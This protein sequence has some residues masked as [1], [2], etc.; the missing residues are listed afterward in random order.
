M[1]GTEERALTD[2]DKEVIGAARAKA[3]ALYRGEVVPHHSCGAALA[4]TFNLSARPYQALRRGGITGERFCGS[5][6]AGELVLGE[7]L[8][9]ESP[10]GAVTDELRAAM[11]WY[12]AQIPSR[13]PR[14]DADYGCSS[15]TRPLGEFMGD[16]RKDFCTSLTAEVAALT[17]EALLRF[18]PDRAINITA[19]DESGED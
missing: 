19:I 13:F 17:A 11:A 15:M 6:R 18:G 12:Q 4:V 3:E 8:G 14:P 10:T 16:A 9:D 1:P 7:I 5:I 2:R